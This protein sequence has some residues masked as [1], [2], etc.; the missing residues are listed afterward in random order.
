M[1]AEAKFLWFVVAIILILGLGFGLDRGETL[2]AFLFGLHWI[3]ILLVVVSIFVL[4]AAM[5]EAL[6]K[7]FLN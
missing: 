6:V 4:L 1:E 3:F 2:I 5:V 7:R